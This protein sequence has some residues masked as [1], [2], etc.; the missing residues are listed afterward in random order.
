M[1]ASTKNYELTM[2]DY[3]CCYLDWLDDQ[4][5]KFHK[6]IITITDHLQAG[7]YESDG[8]FMSKALDYGVVSDISMD[9][10]SSDP[11]K[12][13]LYIAVSTI[14]EKAVEIE[15][16]QWIEFGEGLTIQAR[17]LRYKVVVPYGERVYWVHKKLKTIQ[18][19][20]SLPILTQIEMTGDYT[21]SEVRDSFQEIQSFELD[22]D[23]REHRLFPSIYDII[24]GDVIEKGFEPSEI[25]YVRINSSN[26]N[27]EIRYSPNAQ[28]E[29]PSLE[30]LRTPI[31]GTADFKIKIDPMNTPYIY[32]QRDLVKELDVVSITKGTPQQYSP[33]VLEDF[34]GTPY[35]RVYDI[36][37]DTMFKKEI[38]TIETEDDTHYIKISR[39][40]FDIKTFSIILNDN[41]FNDYRIVNNL[42]IFGDQLKIGDVLEINYRILNSFYAIIDYEKD[43]TKLI[44]YSDYDKEEAKKTDMDSL[45]PIVD[46]HT[47]NKYNVQQMY[48]NGVK[49]KFDK[50]SVEETNL[51][52][53]DADKNAIYMSSN[54]NDF[55]VIINNPLPTAYYSLNTI[56]YSNNNDNDLVGIVIGYIKDN[57]N[58]PHT[59]SYLISLKG[60]NSYT[61]DHGDNTAIVFDYGMTT[62][63]VIATKNIN[64][65][66]YEYWNQMENGIKV[67]VVKHN[68][69]VQCYMSDWNNPDTQNQ[70]SMIEIDLD[71]KQITKVFSGTVMTGYCVRSQEDTYFS[72]TIFSGIIDRTISVEEQMQRIRRKYKVFFET[73]KHNNKFI[74]N[75]LSLNPIYRTD[76]KGFIYLTDKH[77]EPY[78]LRIHCNPKYLKA[79]GYDKIDIVVECLDYIENPVISKEVY[80]DCQEGVLTFDNDRVNQITDMNGVI[81]MTYESAL[82]ACTDTILVRTVTSDGKVISNS[83]EIINE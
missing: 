39:N 67:W 23:G 7:P 58:K 20:V 44:L 29:Y 49:Q 30:A 8:V 66:D 3:L 38:Y 40:D 42:I 26:S 22:T 65:P 60:E 9:I 48:L 5:P 14:D 81:H 17:Y 43:T 50:N 76:Y 62:E 41:E 37:P 64:C 71:D 12:C 25:H 78:Y 19:E 54:E 36:D 16:C 57:Y 69:E 55:C 18:S 45:E 34:D 21:P 35:Q 56:I 47:Y 24:S 1:S 51:W 68:N 59:L 31:Y 33:I 63:T 11:S 82:M 13:K 83:V 46:T 53:Y 73:D 80:I 32:A 79:G 70:D 74:A 6:N 72:N 52:K 27:V 61:F 75:K 28:N 2:E 4:E 77:N 15:N 10:Y